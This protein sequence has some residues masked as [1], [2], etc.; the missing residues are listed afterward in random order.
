MPEINIKHWYKKWWG[1][2]LII[3]GT[4]VL[5]SLTA[6]GFA[7][8]DI[9]KN[10]SLNQIPLDKKNN[11]NEKDIKKIEGEGNY[12]I[13]SANPKITIVEFSDFACPY[14][15]SSFSKIREIGLKYKNEIKYIYR[16]M[17]LHEESTDLA[18]AARCAGEQGL[19]WP[20]HDKLFQNQ[21]VKTENELLELANQIG[22]D[23]N[24]FKICFEGK[25]YLP[26]IQKDYLDGEELKITGTPTW[27]IN[28]GRAS[29]DLPMKAWEEI[30]GELL[31]TK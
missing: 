29:G 20:M 22:A 7:V 17:P 23:K 10:G 21:G 15:K 27:F 1:V 11:L 19:F 2:L 12:W 25:K 18:M 26:L 9:M 16:D 28:G 4:F 5:I 8:Y 31:Q 24:K 3:I 30:I 6:F 14:C 13:G